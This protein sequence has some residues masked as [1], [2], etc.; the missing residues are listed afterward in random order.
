M[1]GFPA[2]F[3]GSSQTEFIV[4][5]HVTVIDS[6]SISVTVYQTLSDH[7]MP[8]SVPVR[9]LLFEGGLVAGLAAIPPNGPPLQGSRGGYSQTMRFV[10][11]HIRTYEIYEGVAVSPLVC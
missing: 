8:D 7:F 1:L 2:F 9:S 5:K 3:A 6:L 4:S 10:S 11:E